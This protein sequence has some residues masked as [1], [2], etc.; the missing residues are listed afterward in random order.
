M[1][2]FLSS[3]S[4]LIMHHP[5]FRI[6]GL[7]PKSNLLAVRILKLLLVGCCL[8]QVCVTLASA[9]NKHVGMAYSSWFPPTTWGSQGG[10]TWAMPALGAYR[11]DNI[12]VIDQHIDWLADAGVDFIFLDWSNND[13]YYP[14]GDRTDLK[15]IEDASEVIFDR[16][17]WRKNNGRSWFEICIMIGV[18]FRDAGYHDGSMN[19]KVNQVKQQYLD[20]PARRSVYYEHRGLP[21]LI[22]YCNG[23]F[24]WT[25]D[26]GW[27][28]T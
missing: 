23:T 18:P 2:F 14:G 24:A 20:N 8:T 4:S 10:C 25:N 11:S 7:H 28:H 5:K 27:N 26:R 22:D 3:F 15:A 1:R 21:L 19:R 12:A 17:V 6:N 9:Q 16:M 13:P